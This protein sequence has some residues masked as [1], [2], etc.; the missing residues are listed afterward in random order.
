MHTILQ[1]GAGCSRHAGHRVVKLTTLCEL[2]EISSSGVTGREL[3]SLFSAILVA[4][5]GRPNLRPTLNY[6]INGHYPARSL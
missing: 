6:R 3:Q 1:A 4:V 2:G 5:K